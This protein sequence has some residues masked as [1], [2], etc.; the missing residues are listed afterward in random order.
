MLIS[1]H[2]N[3]VRDYFGL[4]DG[5][6]LFLNSAPYLANPMISNVGGSR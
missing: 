3:T 5:E 1:R 4:D 2:L 6:L